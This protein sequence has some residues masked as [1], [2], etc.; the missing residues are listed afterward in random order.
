MF[1][2]VQRVWDW[3]ST[4]TEVVAHDICTFPILLSSIR[5]LIMSVQASIASLSD[6]L[7]TTPRHSQRPL[8]N[9]LDTW[10]KNNERQDNACIAQS[11]INHVAEVERNKAVRLAREEDV[12]HT[13]F[14]NDV[15]LKAFKNFMD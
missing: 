15:E 5:L 6:S 2:K 9:H 13:G 11:I 8:V 12:Y 3:R 7:P 14:V 1:E 10:L 4:N